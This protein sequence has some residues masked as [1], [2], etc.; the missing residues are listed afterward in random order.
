MSVDGDI[1]K[2]LE[3]LRSQKLSGMRTLR[4]CMVQQSHHLRCPLRRQL[5]DLAKYTILSFP[6]LD[7][8]QVSETLVGMRE[9][10]FSL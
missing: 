4:R 5:A 3:L 6:D 7:Q 8:C 2:E 1:Q 10:S 9:Q